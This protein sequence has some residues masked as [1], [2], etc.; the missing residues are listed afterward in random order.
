MAETEGQEIAII[1][2]SRNGAVLGAR[3]RELLVGSDLYVSAKLARH[4][5]DGQAR[6]FEG[7]VAAALR[8]I[9]PKYRKLVLFVALGAAVR[10]LAP[11]LKDKRTDPA[12]VVVDD[13]GKHAISALSGHLGG[14]NDLAR[15][16]AALIGAQ[17]VIT[18]ASDMLGT[19]SPDLIGQD[20]G[21]VIENEENLTK[22]SAALVNGEPVGL[23]Q[24]AG[25][26]GWW[27]ADKRWPKNVK[28]FGDL[29]ALAE[30][31]CAAALLIT[32]SLL[33]EECRGL[34]EKSVV[35][36]PKSLV[37]G[38]GCNRGVTASEIEDAVLSVLNEYS[39]S[40]NSVKN[41]ATID[42]KSSEEG[43][44]EFVRSYGLPIVYFTG[45]ELN[46]VRDIPNPSDAIYRTVG[47][48]GV[49]EPAA[50]LSAK[51]DRLLMPKRKI[52]NATIAIARTS[53]DSTSAFSEP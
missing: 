33:D 38:V 29:A 43:L 49:C 46:A 53:F 32:D 3:L 40:M 13:Q 11:L 42:I 22:V 34:L 37:L 20:Y 1:A 7:S 12:V 30:S 15:R 18:T 35:Y 48:R 5:A 28:V 27:P 52:G 31:S 19:F 2:V 9:F 51:T 39:L 8:D 36:R 4:A 25:E 10:L 41:L 47:T 50:M 44:L 17:P 16:V 6:L 24:D 21:W 14:A 45:A 26:R 23:F